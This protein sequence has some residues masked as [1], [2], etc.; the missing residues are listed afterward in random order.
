MPSKI[1]VELN[2]AYKSAT[3]TNARYRILYGGA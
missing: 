3:K 2:P 1:K